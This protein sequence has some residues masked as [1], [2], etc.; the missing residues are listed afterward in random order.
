MSNEQWKIYIVQETAHIAHCS[1]LIAHWAFGVGPPQVRGQGRV[2]RHSNSMLCRPH[3]EG[4]VGL[5]YRVLL[6]K[7][8]RGARQIAEARFVSRQDAVGILTFGGVEGGREVL[9]AVPPHFGDAVIGFEGA[10]G[11]LSVGVERGVQGMAL[12]VALGP[13]GSE[14]IERKW[15]DRGFDI[16]LDVVEAPFRELGSPVLEEVRRFSAREDTVVSVVFQILS[17]SSCRSS[18]VCMSTAAKGSS[19]SRIFGS[20]ESARAS[21]VRCCMPPESWCG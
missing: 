18:R 15:A 16:R 20:F 9:C 1:L 4:D 8:D 11:R 2:R 13:E 21:P 3:H 7:E 10:P 19:I 14:G 17:S 5:K 12:Q 6:G